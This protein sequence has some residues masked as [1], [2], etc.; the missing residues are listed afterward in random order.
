MI[1]IRTIYVKRS[2]VEKKGLR[3][4][5]LCSFIEPLYI[6]TCVSY[7]YTMYVY[8]CDL[9]LPEALCVQVACV[10]HTELLLRLVFL[11]GLKFNSEGF[12]FM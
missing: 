10:N 5:S 8:N 6:T 7:K 2:T 9:V 12:S 3:Y 1:H 11:Q 4:Y